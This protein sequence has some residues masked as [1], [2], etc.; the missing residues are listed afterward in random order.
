MAEYIEREALLVKLR[1]AVSHKGMGA[2]IAG[3]LI[4]YIESIPTADVVEVVHGRW[5]HEECLGV[6]SLNGY[7]CSRCRK[8][9]RR[10]TN[11][12][13]NCGAHMKDGEG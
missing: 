6:V 7:E 13:P 11:Y 1:E 12:C 4:R 10:A 8:N 9:N 3:V 5:M 2:A